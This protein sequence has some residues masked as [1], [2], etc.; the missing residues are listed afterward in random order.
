MH[1]HLQIMWNYLLVFTIKNMKAR[2]P[3]L[4]YLPKTKHKMTQKIPEC[5]LFMLLFYCY[6][7][8]AYIPIMQL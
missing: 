4:S 5:R 8:L 2:L 7:V 6:Y 3:L 1:I